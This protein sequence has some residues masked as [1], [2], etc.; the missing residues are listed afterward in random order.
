MKLPLQPVSVACYE[1]SFCALHTVRIST[2]THT[3]HF[4][5]WRFSGSICNAM[6]VAGE[7][8]LQDLPSRKR[9]DKRLGRRGEEINTGGTHDF[10]DP[11]MKSAAVEH[12][13]KCEQPT[14][15]AEVLTS[16]QRAICRQRQEGSCKEPLSNSG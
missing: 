15:S 8:P 16:I 9:F 12:T 4:V 3:G 1:K 2:K 7:R 13:H 5:C 6:A 11:K 10:L 14:G